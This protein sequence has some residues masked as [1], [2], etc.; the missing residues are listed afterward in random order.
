MLDTH[1]TLWDTPHKSL[2]PKVLL[3][4]DE[5]ANNIWRILPNR[6]DSLSRDIFEFTLQDEEN[7]FWNI[8]VTKK[9][10]E[11]KIL[12]SNVRIIDEQEIWNSSHLIIYDGKEHKLV[13]LDSWWFHMSSWFEDI[14]RNLF[15]WSPMIELT[16][17]LVSRESLWIQTP[18]DR[19]E[20][21]PFRYIGKKA[22]T[23]YWNNFYGI[24]FN[25]KGF[26]EKA[27]KLYKESKFI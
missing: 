12:L 14:K 5:I 13:V 18:D 26:D 4:L 15:Y 25:W 1:Q 19:K 3:N 2:D 20:L 24:D 22:W 21:E 8:S 23:I 9:D 7:W 11:K 17:K 6:T 27:L 16:E 10:S